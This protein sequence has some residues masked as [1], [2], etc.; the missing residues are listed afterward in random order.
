MSKKKKKPFY[1]ERDVMCLCK[2]CRNSYLHRG[3]KVISLGGTTDICDLCN[4]RVGSDY[5]V[6]GLI[7]KNI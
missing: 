7:S 4:Y 3:Y 5:A 1:D 2:V 6:D